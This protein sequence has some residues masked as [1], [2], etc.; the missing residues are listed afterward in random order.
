MNIEGSLVHANALVIYNCILRAS[1]CI[2]GVYVQNCCSVM[3]TSY[4]LLDMGNVSYM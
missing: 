2:G 3:D 1:L 4:S